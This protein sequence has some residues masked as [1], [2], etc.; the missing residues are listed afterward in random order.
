MFIRRRLLLLLPPIIDY[1]Q[2]FYKKASLYLSDDF[3]F[4][5]GQRFYDF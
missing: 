2:T 5:P 1:R 4:F 3:I